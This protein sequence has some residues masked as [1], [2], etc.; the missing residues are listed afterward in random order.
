MKTRKLVVFRTENS[1]VCPGLVANR[2]YLL[3][4]RFW[5]NGEGWYRVQDETT[6]KVHEVPDVFFSVPVA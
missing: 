5:C 3:L 2:A 6:G 4:K 1:V